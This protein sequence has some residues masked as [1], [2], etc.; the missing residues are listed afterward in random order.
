MIFLKKIIMIV[1]LPSIVVASEK[2]NTTITYEENDIVFSAEMQDSIYTYGDTIVIDYE[3]QNNSEKIIYIYNPEYQYSDPIDFGNPVY[4]IE[5]GGEWL[6]N[7]GYGNSIYLSKLNPKENF[8]FRFRF[9]L[10]DNDKNYLEYVK[11]VRTSYV[12]ETR[13]IRFNTSYLPELKNIKIDLNY[14]SGTIKLRDVMLDS[15]I[16]WENQGYL[17]FYGAE[18]GANIEIHLKRS[19][20][21]LFEIKIIDRKPLENAD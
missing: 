1:L 8:K 20:L 3:V 12:N 5:L 6:Y 4:N 18:I 19:I 11:L 14:G 2:G 9:V 10:K 15:L 17:F 7:L 21:G 13:L 16:D